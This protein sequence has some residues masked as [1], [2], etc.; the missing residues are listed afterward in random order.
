MAVG[1]GRENTVE[2]LV[3]KGADVNIKNKDGV[4]V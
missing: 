1:E 4:S 2:H 3:N